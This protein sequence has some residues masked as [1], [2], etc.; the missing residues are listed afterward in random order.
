MVGTAFVGRQRRAGA[1]RPG[2][3]RRP[4]RRTGCGRH[5]RCRDRQDAAPCR[6]HPGL[7]GRAGSGR[8]LPAVVGV[9]A[10]RR[11]LRRALRSDQPSGRPVLDRALA[12]C[13]PYVRPQMAA[14]IPALSDEPPVARLP[15][16]RTRLF[17]A[18]R[19]LLGALGA[20]RRTALVVEDLHWA[21]PGTL[22]LLTFLVRAV[23]GRDRAWS[24][25]AAAMSCR[26]TTLSSTGSLR[27]CGCRGVEPVALAPLSDDDVGTLVASLVDAE[28]AATFVADVVRRGEGNPFFTEQLVAA[29]HDV[30]P[31]LE[32]PAGVPP[33]WR[34]C[35]SPGS[36]RSVAAATDV[37][38]ALAVAARPLA[39]PELALCTGADVDVAAGLRELL[40][41]HLAEPAEL[42]GT[43]SGTPC[44][45]TPCAAPCSRLSG[46]PC[47]PAWRRCSRHAATSLRPRS[48]RT[49]PAQVTAG[50]RRAGRCAPPGTPKVCSPGGRHPPAGIGSGSCGPRLRL[51][52]GRRLGWP[53]QSLRCR[54]RRTIG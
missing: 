2:A 27:P 5:W 48:R 45:R 6:S 41:A 33:G 28:P 44:S 3:A 34:R 25:P 7:P 15:R 24:S 46:P 21:D 29:A 47:T 14:L 54:R 32:V 31:P 53:R 36:G 13:A 1:P 30:A 16:D 49:G 9:A 23:A 38:A 10:I 40:D 8:C 35:C 43:G 37:A 52:T 18:V 39:E 4:G 22:D 11:G 42:T 26:L 20:E 17:A 50:R 51:R 12:R 19:D